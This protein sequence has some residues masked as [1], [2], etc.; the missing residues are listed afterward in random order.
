MRGD[1]ASFEEDLDG[2]SR[3]T[4]IEFFMDQWVRNAVVV[5][6]D[7]D[8]II[9]IDPGPFPFGVNIGM[10][11]K[12]FQNRFL[13]GFE[14]ELPG[15]FELLK[16]TVIQSFEFFCDGLLELAETEEGPVS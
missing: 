3:E 1:S 13:E 8:V 2:G 12:G 6:V 4:N 15:P 9:D 5:V 11:G 14:Q 16:G 10:N 7:L